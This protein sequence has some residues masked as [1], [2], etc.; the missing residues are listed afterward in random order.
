M[1]A[2]IVE[3]FSSFQGEGLWIGKRQIFIRFAGCNLNCNYCDTKNSQNVN[4]GILKSVEEVV[5]KIKE[6]ETP[7][8]HSISFTGG[9]PLL[10]FDFINEII[11]QTDFKIMIETNGTL[12]DSLSKINNLNCVSLDLK[13]PEHFNKD[14][15]E[16]IFNNEI[17]SIKSLIANKKNFYCKIVVSPSTSLA[18]IKELGEKNS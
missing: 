11:S 13:L 4:N 3:I 1:K 15:N 7:D 14:W 18:T 6:L 10:Y 8:L 12:P 17:L 5:K 2:P 16:E 9:E